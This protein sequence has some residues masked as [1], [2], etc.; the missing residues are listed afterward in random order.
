MG[1]AVGTG[2]CAVLRG[3]SGVLAP[4]RGLGKGQMQ[5]RGGVVEW[6]VGGHLRDKRPPQPLG[7]GSKLRV[8][9]PHWGALPGPPE[10][11]LPVPGGSWLW[12]SWLEKGYLLWGQVALSGRPRVHSALAPWASLL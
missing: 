7:A 1:E 9:H 8:G 3:S 10:G 6:G 11:G 5:G 12:R 2:I 4:T